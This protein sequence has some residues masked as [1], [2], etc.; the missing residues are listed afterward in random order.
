VNKFRSYKLRTQLVLPL[1]ADKYSYCRKCSFDTQRTVEY[2]PG[3]EITFVPINQCENREYR[4]SVVLK[5]CELKEFS[6]S[7]TARKS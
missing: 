7:F 6:R 4:D 5:G 1:R 2:N 3:D